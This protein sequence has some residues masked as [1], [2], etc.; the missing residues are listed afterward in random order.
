MD[1]SRALVLVKKEIHTF[2]QPY[3]DILSGQAVHGQVQKFAF[4]KVSS[5]QFWGPSGDV[6][7]VRASCL[8]VLTAL[9]STQVTRSG[10]IQFTV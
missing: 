3:H 2:V 5:A 1:L 4:Q 10:R 6:D 9:L 8:Q 7:N